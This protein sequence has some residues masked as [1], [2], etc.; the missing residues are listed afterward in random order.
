MVKLQ[1]NL[2]AVFSATREERISR[3]KA[4]EEMERKGKI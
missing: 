2:Y 1:K 3:R 4:I